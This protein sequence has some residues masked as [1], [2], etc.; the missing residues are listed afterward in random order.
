MPEFSNKSKEL[1]VDCDGR[2]QKICNAAIE[3]MDFSV[4]SGHRNKEMQDRAFIIGNSKVEYPHSKHNSLPSHAVDIAPYPIDWGD[5]DRFIFLAGIIIATAKT[6]GVKIRW[7]GDWNS[8]FNLK[9]NKFL[10]LGHFEI[11]AEW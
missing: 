3:I 8:D 10:D 9:D 4:I 2:L 1:L 6:Q 5:E 11:V 7:G